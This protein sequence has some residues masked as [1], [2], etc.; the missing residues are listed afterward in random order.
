[1]KLSLSLRM[2]TIALL[3]V[4]V[5]IFWIAQESSAEQTVTVYKD[6]T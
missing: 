4:V 2:L 3:A 5:A 6:P 1:M